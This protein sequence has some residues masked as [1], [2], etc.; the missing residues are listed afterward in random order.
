MLGL[1]VPYNHSLGTPFVFLGRDFLLESYT[2]EKAHETT[3]SVESTQVSDVY[4]RIYILGY[5]KF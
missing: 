5:E 4:F 2:Q 3:N 1:I